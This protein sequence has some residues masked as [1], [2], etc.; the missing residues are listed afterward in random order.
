MSSIL[1][2]NRFLH[3][4]DDTLIDLKG[5]ED[6]CPVCRE[7]GLKSEKK[8]KYG[9]FS[10][11]RCFS[12]STLFLTPLPSPEAISLLYNTNYYN[13]SRLEHGYSDYNADEIYIK[14]SYTRRLKKTINTIRS[15]NKNYVFNHI[16]EIGCALGFGL[17]SVKNLL[18][19]SNISGSDISNDAVSATRKLGFKAEQCDY[20]GKSSIFKKLSLDKANIIYLFD[21]IEHLPDIPVFRKWV[22]KQ[23]KS[24]GYLLITT[25]DM[26]GWLNKILGP[27]SPSIKIPQHIIY[28]ETET[29]T[30]ALKPEFQLVNLWIDFQ[31]V[32]LGV[33][34]NRI[35]HIVGLKPLSFL[36]KF[37]LAILCPNGMKLYLFKKT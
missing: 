15:R 14:Q 20:N 24:D 18:K 19:T 25:P 21:V 31:Y 10:I 26:K 28:F 33:L 3:T 1:H 30:E 12:C 6:H 8:F 27:R 37:R 5:I 35:L 29:L 17:S 11:K 9:D 4:A 13:D 32:G 22:A 7:K 34:L 2:Q 36:E 16:H 23:L